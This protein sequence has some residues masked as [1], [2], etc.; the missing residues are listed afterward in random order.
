MVAEGETVVV[1]CRCR[2]T[3]L[4]E[5]LG[6]PATGRT[7]RW[8]VWFDTVLEGRLD[9]MWSL[10]ATLVSRRSGTPASTRGIA[11]A[12]PSS[13]AH[14]SV[15]YVR[16]HQR[17]ALGDFCRIQ[18]AGAEQ[19]RPAPVV[20]PLGPAE[21][22]RDGVPPPILIEGSRTIREAGAATVG[23]VLPHPERG[24]GRPPSERSGAWGASLARA[25]R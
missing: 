4:G 21:G 3:E 2:G 12:R 11:A 17:G 6:V 20:L 10:G 13:S 14:A 15:N 1:R 24:A 7:M 18:V 22:I 23:R 5:W 8:T 9:R 25:V 19:P 16:F